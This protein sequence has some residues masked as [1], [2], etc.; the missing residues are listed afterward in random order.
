MARRRQDE[1]RAL[2]D[3]DGVR[4]SSMRF[5]MALQSPTKRVSTR[6]QR[7]LARVCLGVCLLTLPAL[8]VALAVSFR[9]GEDGDGY[10]EAAVSSEH[11]LATRAGIQVLRNG[12]NAFD[13]AAVIQ[14]VLGVVQ[15][16]STGLGGGCMALLYKASDGS[17]VALDGREEAPASFGEAA[18][19]KTAACNESWPF[20]PDRVTGGHPVGVPGVLAAVARVLN[21]FGT[22]TLAQALQP[23][24]EV[25]TEG[26][27]MYDHLHSRILANRDRLALF[28]ASAALYLSPDASSPR[29]PVGATF[30]NPDLAATMRAIATGGTA[31]FYEGPIGDDLRA[32]VAAAAN[33]AT[34]LAGNLS[35]ADLAG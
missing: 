30:T 31:A 26:F 14:L 18:F 27:P 2:H 10:R 33:P 15:P 4:T 23:A 8:L 24:I 19:C 22:L 35:A 17:V 9:S 13:A 11:Y 7:R 12:G 29:V 32:A 25:A 5:E 21:E 20:F 28:N 1:L 16:Q 3:A 34:G 6:C